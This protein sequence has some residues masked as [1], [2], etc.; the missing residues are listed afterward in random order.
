MKVYVLDAFERTGIQYITEVA[1][2]SVQYGDPRGKDWHDDAVGLMI[3]GT[4]LTAQD[5]AKAKKL[6]VVAK[7][8][9]GVDNIDLDAAKAH[10]VIVC[11]TPGVNSHAVAELAFALTLAVARRIP[12]FDRRVRAGEKIVRPNYLGFEMQGKTVGII[13]MGNIGVHAARMFRNAFGCRILAYD[14]YAPAN[15]WPDLPHERITRLD[16][17]WPQ[18]DVLTLHVPLTSE[19]RNIVDATAIAN[20]REGAII[21]NVS[22]GGLI[23]E[24][25]LYQA[26]KSGKL[27]GAG[28]DAFEEG[29]PPSPSNPLLSLPSVVATP[30]AGGGTRE[31]Q[32]RSSLKTAQQLWQV[33]NGGEPFHRV[34]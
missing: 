17:M 10:G 27:F 24:A 12:E 1:P 31:T 4:V 8:G 25:A 18:V 26:L 13:G 15:H 33:L 3:R 16:Q 28:L 7:Q 29:E 20:L 34:V 2:D 32:V 5:F 22:R 21:T 9:V 30:H 19:T 14:P 6:K 23:D 11:T